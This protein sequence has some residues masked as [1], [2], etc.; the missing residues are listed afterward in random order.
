MLG[1]LKST[2]QSQQI[3]DPETSASVDK[4]FAA[5]TYYIYPPRRIQQTQFYKLTL[6]LRFHRSVAFLQ[7]LLIDDPISVPT[8]ENLMNSCK[9]IL[10]VL[11]KVYIAYQHR[12]YSIMVII[13][14]SQ[15][16]RQWVDAKK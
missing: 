7:Y 9:Q 5:V 14:G 15:T 8:K 11:K 2:Y 12:I 10:L 3:F 16:R 1:D 4:M 13:A 6:S